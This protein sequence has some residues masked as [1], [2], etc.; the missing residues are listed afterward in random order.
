MSNYDQ[1]IIKPKLGLLELAKQL[2]SVSTA[3]KV[4]GYSRDSFY[5]FKE[6]YEMGGE[7][8]LVDMSR[9]KPIVKNRVSEHIE[10]AVINLAI[11]NPALGQLRASQALIKQGIIVSSSGVR[12]IWLRNDLETLKKRL[13]ALE[14]KSAQDGILL[15]E[16]QI[17]ALKKAK[18]IKEAHGEIDTQHPGYLGAQDTYYVG[19]MKGVGR[20]YQQTFIDTYSRV[21]ICKLYTDKSAITSADILNDKVIPFFNNHDVP[22]L[23]ILTD[24][25]TEYCG[26]VEHHAFELYLA[27]E[28]IDHTKTKA[29]SPQTNGICERLHRTL[30]DEFYDIAFRKKIYSS[31]EDLQIDLD[32]YLNKYNNTRPH[33]GKFCYG[34][35]PMQTFKDSIK[36]AQD[37]SINSYLSDSTF[38]A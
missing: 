7:A 18:Q 12:S 13:K 22:L 10:Q 9:K 16:E 34:K 17:S 11:E 31:L 21:A 37:K 19:N 14:A 3:C 27:I 4:M 32:Q 8:A 5:R 25:G 2:G 30:K 23:R 29:R 24:R 1:K 6:L 38:A 15:T 20:I 33:S 35:T 36:I 26:K 28:N